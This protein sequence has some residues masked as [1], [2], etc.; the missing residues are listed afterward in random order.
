MMCGHEKPCLVLVR[1]SLLGKILRRKRTRASRTGMRAVIVE[2]RVSPHE[3]VCRKAAFL[4]RADPN[5]LTIL[6][7]SFVEVKT[8]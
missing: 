5:F 2:I 7:F 8:K 4:M 1:L 6:W 3:P